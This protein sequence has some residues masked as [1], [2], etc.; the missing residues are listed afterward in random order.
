MRKLIAVLLILL[1]S[2]VAALWLHRLGGIVLIS[3]GDWTVQTSVLIF[4]IIVV[5]ALA[6]LYALVVVLR[7][8]LG[9][10]G[11]FGDWRRQRREHRARAHLTKGLLRLAEGRSSDAEKLL[12]KDVERSEAPLLHYLAAAIAAQ[13]HSSYERRDRYLALADKSS[14]KAGLAVGLIQAHLQIESQQWE[15]AL[16]TLSYLH[17]EAPNHPRVQAL[18]LRT[19]EALEEWDRLELLLPS[20]RRQQALPESE[21]RRLEHELA[22][23]RLSRAAT[24][25]QGA[26]LE[27]VWARLSKGLR[28]DPDLLL[29]YLDGLIASGQSEQAERLLRTHLAKEYDQELVQR[30]GLLPISAPHKALAQVEKW[31][32]NRPDDAALLQ[33]AGRFALQANLWGRARSYLEAAIACKPEPATCYLLGALLEKSGETDAAREYY[34]RAL[35]HSSSDDHLQLTAAEERALAEISSQ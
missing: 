30:Y 15:Q 7:G 8:L 18:L 1:L 2:V 10:P 19:C 25:D 13:R 20:A 24:D 26:E 22:L 32:L 31:L 33:A 6:I 5:A 3:F 17:E 4:A 28:Q 23:Q 12:L 27:K 14:T 35:E 34:R 9:M 21:L 29:V 11:R 16:A